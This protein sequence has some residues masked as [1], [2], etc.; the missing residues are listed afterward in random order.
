[1]STV[2]GPLRKASR[3]VRRQQLIESTIAVLARRGY[4]ALT[5]ADVAKEA[6]LSAGIVIFH[7]NSKD[8]L[9]ADALTFLA[10]EYRSHWEERVNGAGPSPAARLQALLLAD[11]DP[12]VFTREKLAAWIAFWGETQ[13]RPV[14]DQICAGL[15]AERQAA[16]E[17]LCR[18]LDAE[19]GYG[20]DSHI[21]MQSL[22]SL[23][24]GL[25][26]RMASEE[27]RPTSHLSA[28][29]AQRILLAALR[30]FFPRHYGP[31]A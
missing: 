25:W 16:T 30:A 12:A 1:M 20:L 6:G 14:Y 13:G 31:G 2:A 4:A 11:H 24:D 9:L 22:E 17:S 10:A 28:A 18:E 3:S 5:V 23:G 26:L 8:E 19:G 21:V 7:F 29:D 15:D 27:T